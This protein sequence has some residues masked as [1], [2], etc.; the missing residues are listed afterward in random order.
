MRRFLVVLSIVVLATPG[1]MAQ[2]QPPPV[3]GGG[4]GCQD[5]IA[6]NA[7]MTTYCLTA[8]GGCCATTWYGCSPGPY[9]CLC[10]PFGN[11]WLQCECLPECGE[12][13]LWA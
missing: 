4:N 3:G 12:P 11:G 1:L 9:R 7:S 5:C 8:E 13:C 6:V 10:M 2:V